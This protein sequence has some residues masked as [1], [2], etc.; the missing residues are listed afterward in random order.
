MRN[1]IPLVL[2]VFVPLLSRMS[3]AQ[4]PVDSAPS[5][6]VGPHGDY[7]FPREGGLSVAFGTG[8]PFLGIGEVAYGVGSGF[9]LGAVGAATPDVG[10][11]RGTTALGVRP[12]GVLF[13]A[14][15][16]RS[17]LVAPVLYYPG[18]SGFGGPRDPW[19]L[20]RPEVALE[21]EIGSGTL[22]NVALGVVAAACTESL[23]TLGKE[24]SATFMGGVWNT[25]RVGAAVPLTARVSLFGETSLVL[26]GFRPASTW[27]GE[28]PVIAVFGV[29]AGL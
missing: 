13:R 4:T 21:R 6:A 2:V 15:R 16:W 20:T 24:H 29:A 26:R 12:R 1:P 25:A 3:V 10:S 17:V 11:V 19:M 9:A 28:A 14:S 23:V 7:L 27:I 8:V 5:P 22:V 18:V